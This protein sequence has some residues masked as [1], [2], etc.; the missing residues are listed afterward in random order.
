MPLK[1]NFPKIVRSLDLSDYA[2]EW[3]DQRVYVWVNPDQDTLIALADLQ[4]MI[5]DKQNLPAQKEQLEKASADIQARLEVIKKKPKENQAEIEQITKL[6]E[7]GQKYLK[8]Y[9]ERLAELEGLDIEETE[10]QY[11]KLFS[12]ILSEGTDKETHLS[13]DDLKELK[14]ATQATDPAFWTWFQTAVIEKI[15]AHRLRQKKA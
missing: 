13:V 5:Q 2:P 10:E 14:E 6:M 11:L 9:E 7:D 8:F 15:N 1:L 3:G 12:G 4:K